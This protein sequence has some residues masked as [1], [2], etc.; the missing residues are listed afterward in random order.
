MKQSSKSFYA[1]LYQVYGSWFRRVSTSTNDNNLRKQM[2][3]RI[4]Y[5]KCQRLHVK[6]NLTDHGKLPRWTWESSG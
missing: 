3:T 1:H 5:M 6:Q 4:Q 2:T